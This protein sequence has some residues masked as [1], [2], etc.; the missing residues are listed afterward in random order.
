MAGDA[1]NA[2]CSFLF[3]LW[4]A[5]ADAPAL[6]RLVLGYPRRELFTYSTALISEKDPGGLLVS[7]MRR[8]DYYYHCPALG[9]GQ[10]EPDTLG[11]EPSLL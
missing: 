2:G 10:D 1:A 8:F 6:D 5:H 4:Q 11:S 9:H 3:L 7:I